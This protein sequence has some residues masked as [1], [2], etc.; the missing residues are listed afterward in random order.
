MTTN[1]MPT[2]EEVLASL[3][4]SGLS[5]DK[6]A[7]FDAFKTLYPSLNEVE[8]VELLKSVL[9]HVDTLLY[10]PSAKTG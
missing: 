5:A 10:K 6:N 8:R 7:F 9:A 3:K 4:K 2:P 1:P